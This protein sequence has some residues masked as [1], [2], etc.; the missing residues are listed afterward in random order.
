[1]R[2]VGNIALGVSV[3]TLLLAPA[4]V[5][6]QSGVTS[7]SQ[8]VPDSTHLNEQARHQLDLALNANGLVGADV[9]P[10]HLKVDFQMSLN[11]ADGPKSFSGSMEEWYA[12]PYRW[13]R[14]YKAERPNW[15]GSE[16]SV[17][18]TERYAKKDQHAE[19]DDYSLMSN[20]ARPLIDPLFQVA[21]IKPTDEM[22]VRRLA[23]ANVALNC[24][25]LS[26]KSAAEHGKFPEWLVPTTCFDDHFHLRLIR[27]EKTLLRFDAIQMFQG[28]AIA[29]DVTI[30]F[31]GHLSAEIKV[32]LLD[33]VE[34][35]DE[36]LLK[37]PSDAAFR[38][39]VIERGYPKPVSVYEVGAHLQP[40]P[41]GQPFTGTLLVPVFIQK[42]GTV[43]LQR[44]VS[45]DSSLGQIFKEVYKAVAKW[46]FQ[47]YLVDGQ[48]VEADYDAPYETDGKPYVPSY[49]RTPV[50]GNDVA[51]THPGI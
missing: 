35:V 7:D 47:P 17:S 8:T 1:M 13:V 19:L 32:T 41:N 3:A 48:P 44:G 21:N 31:D 42:D 20:I 46:R 26:E 9:K 36:A 27:S 39:Y 50:P 37:P 43:K 15:S 11:F 6:T 28:R 12:G 49:Q 34:S 23:T 24:V 5:F 45:D 25:S 14:T 30:T 33:A 2:S 10:W 29:R 38:P 22:V 4:A 18:K 51:G 40:M 16:W